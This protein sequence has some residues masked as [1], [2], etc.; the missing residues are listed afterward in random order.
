MHC[1]AALHDEDAPPPLPRISPSRQSISL[2]PAS[3]SHSQASPEAFNST[4]PEVSNA[5]MNSDLGGSR[6]FELEDGSLLGRSPIPSQTED[7]DMHGGS[8]DR[9][10]RAIDSEIGSENVP[11]PGSAVPSPSQRNPE[12]EDCASG[13]TSFPCTTVFWKRST[14]TSSSTLTETRC[15]C[16]LCSDDRDF[17]HVRKKAIHE[18]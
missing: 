8:G 17:I 4:A 18:V 10:P 5:R 1:R 3:G 14:Y 12:E 16:L 2:N 9:N 13:S 6:D 11:S 7:T 15:V